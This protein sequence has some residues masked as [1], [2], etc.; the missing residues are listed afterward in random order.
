[1]SHADP[2]L[3]YKLSD[4]YAGSSDHHLLQYGQWLKAELASI[5]SLIKDEKRGGCALKITPQYRFVKWQIKFQPCGDDP[6][7]RPTN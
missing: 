2:H 7:S 5:L 1:V 4:A 6:Y 3:G